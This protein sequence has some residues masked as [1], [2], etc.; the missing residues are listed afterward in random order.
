MSRLGKSRLEDGSLACMFHGGAFESGSMT[1]RFFV[2][3]TTAW[4]A[5]PREA[6]GKVPV[7]DPRS[8]AQARFGPKYKLDFTKRTIGRSENGDENEP[9]CETSRLD[10]L[11]H[12]ALYQG[13]VPR[14][15][16]VGHARILAGN[17]RRL[18][19]RRRQRHD[20]TTCSMG[21]L[22]NYRHLDFCRS[23]LGVV[24][25]G[26]F[27]RRFR[28]CNRFGWL[29]AFHV[30]GLSFNYS[31]QLGQYPHCT[32]G[33]TCRRMA[34]AQHWRASPATLAPNASPCNGLQICQQ[35]HWSNYPRKPHTRFNCRGQNPG[36]SASIPGQ[37]RCHS[38]EHICSKLRHSAFD[39]HVLP[40]WQTP[41]LHSPKF[42]A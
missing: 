34:K 13:G 8:C 35:I 19:G 41:V 39:N 29:G 9:T 1:E 7:S 28:F 26:T 17:F 38:K 15:G 36:S 31:N 2:R 32:V 25:S 27:A 6:D 5:M 33:P 20:R 10:L 40:H 18:T 24:C 22:D 12:V 30:N 11:R 4:R 42:C 16:G 14:C 37:Y 21:L 3:L 23:I